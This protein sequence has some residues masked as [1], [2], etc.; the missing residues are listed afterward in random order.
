M[1]SI[2]PCLWF[3]ENNAE[4]AVDFYTSIFR[5]SKVKETLL[6]TENNEHGKN[7]EPMLITF[8]LLGRDVSALNGKPYVTFNHAIS[9]AVPC[10]NQDEIDYLW[11]KL[12]DGGKV[13]QCGWLKDKYGVSWQIFPAAINDMLRD[14]KKAQ[15][16]MKA[17]MKMVKID[18]KTLQD[19]YVIG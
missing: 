14:P 15:G 13:E 2:I 8:T 19:A 1:Q 17:M 4:E 11:D 10:N 18:L 12:S 5:D 6:Y 7:G 9:F 3:E 16:V